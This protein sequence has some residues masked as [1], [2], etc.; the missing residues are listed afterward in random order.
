MAEIALGLIMA[1][2]G[3]VAG[4][5]VATQTGMKFKAVKTDL[6]KQVYLRPCIGAHD[7]LCDRK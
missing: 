3:F 6:P 5:R 4:G 7:T 2:F 1:V